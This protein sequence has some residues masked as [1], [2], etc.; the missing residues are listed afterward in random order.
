MGQI[1]VRPTRSEL[2]KLS[3]PGNPFDLESFGWGWLAGSIATVV[4]GGVV[5]Y[6]SAPYIIKGLG[7]TGEIIRVLQVLEG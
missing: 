1:V 3:N 6:F 2:A 5:L 7:M 4:V